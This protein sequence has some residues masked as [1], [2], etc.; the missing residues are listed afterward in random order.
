MRRTIS[1]LGLAW[2]MIL[3]T[4]S[5]AP[6]QASDPTPSGEPEVRCPA[7]PVAGGWFLI[8]HRMLVG[9]LPAPFGAGGGGVG[10]PTVKVKDR[11]CVVEATLAGLTIEFTHVGSDFESVQNWLLA[12]SSAAMLVDRGQNPKLGNPVARWKEGQRKDWD[13]LDVLLPLG[14]AIH[15]MKGWLTDGSLG[16][17]YPG[18]ADTTSKWDKAVAGGVKAFY[19]GTM[20]GEPNIFWILAVKSPRLMR[21]IHGFTAMGTGAIDAPP[22]LQKHAWLYSP[23]FFVEDANTTLDDEAIMEMLLLATTAKGIDQL[24]FEEWRLDEAPPASDDELELPA[25]PDDELEPPAS[26]D[27]ELEPA[28]EDGPPGPVERP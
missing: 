7:H 14:L 16:G 4:L 22:H 13:G 5:G 8:A 9:G 6:I 2:L 23:D 20:P 24:E 28:P 17:G 18:D 27:D 1:S 15:G 3:P 10:H 12:H 25:S 19:A 26:P 21:S 11:G